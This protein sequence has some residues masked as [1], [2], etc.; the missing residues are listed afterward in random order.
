[1][2]GVPRIFEKIYQGA[3]AKAKAGG[4]AKAKIFD[5]AFNTSANVKAKQRAGESAGPFAGIQMA[6]ADK[7]VFSKIRELTGGRIQHLRAPAPPRSTA[8]SPAGSTRPACR[9]SRATA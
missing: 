4:G 9:S 1:M 7:L 5:W 3:N 6:I 2:A 8:T